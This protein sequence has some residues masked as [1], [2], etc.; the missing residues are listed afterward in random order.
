MELT[1]KQRQAVTKKKAPTNRGAER[2]GK[3]RILD[4]LLELTGELE[5]LA[6][7][8]KPAT[9]KPTIDRAWNACPWR[10]FS[11]EAMNHLPGGID[12]RQWGAD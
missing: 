10:R 9:V 8:K 1:M 11:V 12:M 2:A 3:P 6:L 4:E 5:T 7:A